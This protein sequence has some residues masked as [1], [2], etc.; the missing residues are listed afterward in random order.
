[1]FINKN[2]DTQRV[3]YIASGQKEIAKL[4][5]K[6]IFKVFTTEDISS[7]IQIFNSRFVDEIKNLDTDKAYDKSWLV[8]QAYNDQERNLILT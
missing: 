8:V 1:M 4:L 6:S 2:P 3:Q 5:E 7:N